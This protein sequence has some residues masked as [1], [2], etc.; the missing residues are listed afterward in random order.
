MDSYG[1]AGCLRMDMDHDKARASVRQCA[2]N[3]RPN[4][5]LGSARRRRCFT[6]R[7][8]GTTAAPPPPRSPAVAAPPA[9]RTMMRPWDVARSKGASGRA[10]PLTLDGHQLQISPPI[11]VIKPGSIPNRSW[12]AALRTLREAMGLDRDQTAKLA[13]VSVETVRAYEVGRRQPSRGT[14][15]RLLLA[16]RASRLDRNRVLLGA[17]FREDDQPPGV[18]PDAPDLRFDEAV[19]EILASPWPA[20]VCDDVAT[21]LAANP[22]IL[23]LWEAPT[24]WEQLTPVERNLFARLSEPA[25]GDRVDNREEV[26][27]YAIATY[28]AHYGAEAIATGSSPYL[29]A[30]VDRF[31]NGRSVYLRRFA[32][33]WA[34]TAPA[35]RK[36]RFRFPLIWR[37]GAGG[38]R[39]F[40]VVS[41][42]N[43]AN[44][45]F[46]Y[47]RVPVDNEDG[48]RS[49]SPS[50]A[51]EPRTSRRG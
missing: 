13:G 22:A 17:G 26:A 37:T 16:L 6:P 45:L 27:S 47:D 18:E 30:I 19:S 14:L 15:L 38:R 9:I 51:A 3:E 41:L 25:F 49:P 48:P 40:V 35:L 34:T 36:R 29:A 20:C 46:V 31:M 23:R 12:R 44:G 5:Q 50:P 24:G 8:L 32:R 11:S 43:L 1:T 21:V 28:K 7:W 2:P 42:V 10:E 4:G 33:V 39:R